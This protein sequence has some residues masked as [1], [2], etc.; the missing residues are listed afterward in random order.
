MSDSL[1]EQVLQKE[2]DE[3]KFFIFLEILEMLHL[4]KYKKLDFAHKY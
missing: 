1:L 2:E 3:E 4:A